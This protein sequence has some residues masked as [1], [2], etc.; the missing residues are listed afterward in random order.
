MPAPEKLLYSPRD[1]AKRYGTTAHHVRHV[2]DRLGVC[3]RL[4]TYRGILS[5]DLPLVES[6]LIAAGKIPRRR[7]EPVGA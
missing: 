1:L 3:H 4:G 7:P 5:K 6:G 2:V